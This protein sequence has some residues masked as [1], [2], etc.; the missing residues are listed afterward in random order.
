MAFEWDCDCGWE[1]ELDKWAPPP[2]PPFFNVPPPPVPP[3]LMAAAAA[4]SAN[5]VTVED[6]CSDDHVQLGDTCQAF[7]V[8]TWTTSMENTRLSFL[9]LPT[10][11]A[12]PLHPA[13]LFVRRA[14]NPPRV[15]T[16]L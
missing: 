10:S 1:V 16:E 9:L 7:L 3:S 13:A 4:N 11:L 14:A 15:C 5:S 6:V 12:G 8:K 2:P